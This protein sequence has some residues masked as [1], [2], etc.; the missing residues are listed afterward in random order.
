MFSGVDTAYTKQYAVFSGLDTA[1]TKQN[2]AFPGLDTK[3]HW[4]ILSKKY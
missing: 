3:G 2:A 1:Y 4:Y